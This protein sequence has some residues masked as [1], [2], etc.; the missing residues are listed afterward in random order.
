MIKREITTIA[1]VWQFHGF[2]VALSV[3]LYY[4]LPSFLIFIALA[5]GLALMGVMTL[6]VKKRFSDNLVR[7]K[8][9]QGFSGLIHAIVF[10][11]LFALL[12]GKD[13]RGIFS[14]FILL[15][16]IVV[17]LVISINAAYYKLK[18][19]ET[20]SARKKFLTVF[21]VLSIPLW[22]WFN[23]VVK[24]NFLLRAQGLCIVMSIMQCILTTNFSRAREFIDIN[25]LSSN[26]D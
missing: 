15:F 26:S 2:F 1:E 24:N 14:I 21:M 22:F 5:I 18:I 20:S 11:F 4:Y 17:V 16:A 19:W 6:F 8:M 10:S 13:L 3:A 23:S 12:T 7:V 25:N 9:L